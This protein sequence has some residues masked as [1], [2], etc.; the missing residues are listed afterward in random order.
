MTKAMVADAVTTVR[1]RTGSAE[2]STRLV[3]GC[4]R[5]K[6]IYESGDVVRWVPFKETFHIDGV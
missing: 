1:A 4:K 2:N 6:L 5:N 3:S